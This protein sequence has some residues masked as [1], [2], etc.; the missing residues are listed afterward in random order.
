MTQ[1]WQIAAG[2]KTRNYADIFLEHDCMFLGP[3]G[4]GPYT[5]EVYQPLIKNRLWKAQ[6]INSI[7]TFAETVK[8]NDIILLRKTHRVVAIGIVPEDGYDHNDAFDDV[9]GWDLQH[10]R[11]VVWQR[12]LEVELDKIQANK[13]LFGGR[14]QIPMFTR[15][16]DK[17]I[18]D[19]I[20]HLFDKCGPRPLKPMPQKLPDPLTIE[21]LGEELFLKGLPNEA[22]E[23]VILAIKRQRRLVKWYEKQREPSEHEVV[24][25]M[26]LPFMLALGWSEQLLAVEW[27]WI[28]LAVFSTA[29]IKSENLCLLCEAKGLGQGLQDVFS[30]AKGYVDKFKLDKCKRILLTDG[31]RLYLHQRKKDD[32][33]DENPVGYLNV[34]L[35]RTN[36]IA[37]AGTNA[38]D[39][40]M[41]L[42]PAGITREVGK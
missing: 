6:K 10:T 22:V 24:A 28:D 20:Q 5:D 27:N 4:Y 19:P 18:L 3:G 33:W 35:I 36:H 32:S 15:V 26:I 16:S 40:I 13:D 41:A 12:H 31:E 21:Q 17:T 9:Y 42:T 7:K 25:H 8:A 23:R 38:V 2:E 34:K 1:V 11:R 37:P 29:P 39:T 30:Q 14:K